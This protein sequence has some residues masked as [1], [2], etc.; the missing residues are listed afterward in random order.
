MTLHLGSAVLVFSVFRAHRARPALTTKTLSKVEE[1]LKPGR[2]KD[3]LRV[4]G[5]AEV[6]SFIAVQAR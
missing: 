1:L 6:G 5:L 3:S 2:F 4:G